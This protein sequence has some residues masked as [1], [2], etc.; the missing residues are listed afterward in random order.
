MKGVRSDSG[1]LRMYCSPPGV[2]PAAHVVLRM[3][4]SLHSAHLRLIILLRPS[5]CRCS[6]VQ[7]NSDE[8][9]A[10]GLC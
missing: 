4:G 2:P 10:D 3:Q 8:C 1:M 9:I 6:Q 7:H 5:L